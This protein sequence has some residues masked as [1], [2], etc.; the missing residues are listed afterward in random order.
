MRPSEALGRLKPEET[1]VKRGSETLALPLRSTLWLLLGSWLGAWL[2]FVAGVAPT[3][4]RVLPSTEVAGSLISPLLRGLHLYGIMAGIGIA[5]LGLALGR[6]GLLLALPLAM[7]AVCGFSEFWVTT[8][9]GL[10][11]PEAFGPGATPEAA[12]RF[13]TLHV[14]SRSLY[15]AVAAGLVATTILQT[16]ADLR[17]DAPASR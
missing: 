11:R 15:F 13:S 17:L 9:I 10:V 16:R 4:F 12:A 14:A 8:N 6:R 7:A 2:L 1:P 5:T 3:A